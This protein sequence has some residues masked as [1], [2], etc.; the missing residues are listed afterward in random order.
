MEAAKGKKRRERKTAAKKAE[1]PAAARECD[2]FVETGGELDGP[3]QEEQ[4]HGDGGRAGGSLSNT[5]T[6]TSDR[7][8]A[9]EDCKHK[10]CS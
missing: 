4:G 8:R 2:F 1:K 9:A 7:R 10:S 6:A 3:G 5:S